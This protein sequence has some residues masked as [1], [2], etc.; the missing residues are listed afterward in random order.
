MWVIDET[1]P[2]IPFES[3]G[4]NPSKTGL[5]KFEYYER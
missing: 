2:R 5:K 4:N 3:D 1:Y